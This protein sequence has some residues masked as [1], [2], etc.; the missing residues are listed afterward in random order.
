MTGIDIAD[1]IFPELLRVIY[2]ETPF[3][4][5][6]INGDGYEDLIVGAYTNDAGGQKPEEF[7]FI[8]E[9]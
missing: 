1:E 5:K 9:A 6:D 2:S 4:G 8:L 7:M 3:L